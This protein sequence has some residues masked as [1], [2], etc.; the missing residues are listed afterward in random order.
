MATVN[1]SRLQLYLDAEV[2]ILAGQRIQLGER[3]LTM[4]DLSEVR[5]EINSLQ[6]SVNAEGRVASG[7]ARFATADFGGRT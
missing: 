1:E 3:Q 4:A 6:R 2:K 7:T 5:A